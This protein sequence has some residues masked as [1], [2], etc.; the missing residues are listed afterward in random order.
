MR[1]FSL[2]MTLIRVFTSY[3]WLILCRFVVKN[4][5]LDGRN[6]SNFS[7]SGSILVDRNQQELTLK[8]LEPLVRYEVIVSS[9]VSYNATIK[10]SHMVMS[11]PSDA[12][13]F[14]TREYPAL[15]HLFRS[16]IHSIWC[17]SRKI[18]LV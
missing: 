15:G 17:C 2:L 10:V 5:A 16:E 7:Y 11:E 12:I 3:V 9:F 6:N 1:L 8:N 13:I 18:N 4:Q 14:Q